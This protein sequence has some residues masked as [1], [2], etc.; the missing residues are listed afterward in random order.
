MLRL[1]LTAVM[2]LS[3]GISSADVN[4]GDLR[5]DPVMGT[6]V[7]LRAGTFEP[8][9]LPVTVPD[10]W[11]GTRAPDYDYYLIMLQP[12]ATRTGREALRGCGAELVEYIPYN[13]YLVRLPDH[14]LPV[15]QS[16]PLVAWSTLWHPWFKTQPC[17]H[18]RV[19]SVEV[20]V[21]LHP[22]ESAL[23]PMRSLESAGLQPVGMLMGPEQWVVRVSLPVS[24]LATVA[25]WREVQW[26]EEHLP[27]H[28]LNQNAQWVTQSFVGGSRPVWDAGL[29]GDDQIIEVNDSGVR[30][31]H[32]AF[33]DAAVPITD[34]GAFPTHRKIL[35]YL[36]G[37]PAGTG[38]FG[39][40]YDPYPPY[41]HGTHVACSMAGDD[42][43]WTV[44]DG[45]AKTAKL[46]VTDIGVAG[47]LNSS[48][49]Y[50][51][52]S[53]ANGYG[54]TIHNCSWGQDTEGDYNTYDSSCDSYM[55]WEPYELACI[56]AGNNPPN[57]YTGSPANAK[58]ILC[59]GASKNSSNGNQFAYWTA[60]GPTTDGRYAPTLLTPGE[61]VNSASNNSDGGYA[62]SD[63]TSMASPIASG[64]AAL[65]RSYFMKGYYPGGSVSPA[66]SFTPLNS[67]IK[68]TMVAATRDPVGLQPPSNRSGWG[69]VVLDDALFFGARSRT[70][71]VYQDTAGIAEGESDS[72]EI[73]AEAGGELKIVLCWSDKPGSL[74]GSGPKIKND[75]DLEVQ[76]PGGAT[77][78]GNV[79][80]GGGSATG[81]T[82]D[83]LNTTEVVWL[84]TPV[85]GEYTITVTYYASVQDDP[86]RFALVAVGEGVAASGADTE[87]PT[88][89]SGAQLAGDGMLSWSPSTDNVG[90]TGYRVYRAT[91]AHFDVGS[92]L[93]PFG[94]TTGTSYSVAGSLGD[95]AVNY[96]FRITAHDAALNESDPSN[97]VGE[98]DYQLDDGT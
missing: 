87:A 74:A 11:R 25:G 17:L 43:D 48:M 50:T 95:P 81:G 10:G 55:W 91:Q 68:G 4:T 30:T 61:S 56:A 94:T 16:H 92:G 39:D 77:Y 54:A 7:L 37:T 35:A 89:P 23:G 26:I 60:R 63:G 85:A 75:L 38:L 31:T 33:V 18:D 90:V 45:M 47:G 84:R 14:S 72:W 62:S 78:L 22:R 86:Q 3:V 28:V 82:A 80:S 12:P 49:P 15:V 98:H 5:S 83:R 53:T 70:M 42:G 97:T 2:L 73:T 57:Y 8:T 24:M 34:F 21:A 41:G 46:V 76:A 52:F 51:M 79:F 59:V 93:A 9:R 96:Y 65:V 66:H 44:K 64:C 32:Y 58:S 71:W 20:N 69:F 67:L 27:L 88:A 13:T 29:T 6:T 40:E 1:V 36:D 19:G